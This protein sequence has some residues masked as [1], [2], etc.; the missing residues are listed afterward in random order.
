MSKC[1]IIMEDADTG[2]SIHTYKFIS[3]AV[4]CGHSFV[5]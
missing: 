1:G 4:E 5:Y 3:I 2:N